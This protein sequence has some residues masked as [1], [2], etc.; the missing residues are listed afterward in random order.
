MSREQ[1]H[2]MSE[3]LR[4][5]DFIL[6]TGS[7]LHPL[8]SFHTPSVPSSP[9]S[10]PSLRSNP[11][12]YSL[13]FFWGALCAPQRGLGRAINVLT[14]ITLRS[15]RS[16]LIGR[17]Q[18]YTLLRSILWNQ[19]TTSFQYLHCHSSAADSPYL[20]H[21][22]LSRSLFSLTIH[23]FS[24]FHAEYEDYLFNNFLLLS[25]ERLLRNSI[26]IRRNSVFMLQFSC[27]IFHVRY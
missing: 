1:H 22:I 2:I 12:N 9:L 20:E 24:Y 7:S 3:L 5:L 25:S 19:L 11:L 16:G 23:L 6:F 26:V 18:G 21:I 15:F 27:L 8:P 14:Y 17:F 13:K 10:L 4:A